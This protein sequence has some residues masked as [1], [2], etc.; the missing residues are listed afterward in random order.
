MFCNELAS[1]S[2]SKN[3]SNYS[4]INGILFDKCLTTLIAYPAAKQDTSY[5]IPDGV[6]AVSYT[7]LIQSGLARPVA[8]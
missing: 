8:C 3:N 2:V 5:T 4:D 6:I 7:H 1:I